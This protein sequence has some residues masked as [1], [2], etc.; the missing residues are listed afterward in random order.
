MQWFNI[1]S[2]AFIM[3]AID[4]LAV[5][6]LIYF[7][8]SLSNDRRTLLMV[9]GIIF[10]LIA[11]VL[12]DRLGMR[13]LNFVLDKLLIG[14]AV[15][16]AVILQPELRRFL[17]R[18][19]RGDLLSLI[20]P[21]TNR[22]SP[23]ETDSV[24]EEIN[25]AVIELSQN[26]TGAL[27]IIET[28]EP[29]DD[30]DFSVPGVRLN[31]LLSKELLHTIFQTSTLLHDGA[32]LIREDRILAAGVILPIS[33]RAASREIGT[34]HRAAMGITDRVRNCF[35]IVVSEETGSIAIAE[36]GILD[37]PIS[38]SRLRE[39]LETKLGNYR[40]TTLG[41][42]VPRFNWLWSNSIFKNMVSRKSSEKK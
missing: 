32:I 20:Q 21:T 40:P 9:R 26:R 4:I 17:E 34:R 27:M 30:R 36:N 24:I 10:L 35:C 15:A 31:A 11:S 38:S 13:L 16:M 25:D 22:R 6:G 42:T 5:L 7:M 12:S 14:A 39:I 2:I 19:G 18:L 8:L 33:E 1:N 28:G 23:V 41:G 3:R 29:I 37:R